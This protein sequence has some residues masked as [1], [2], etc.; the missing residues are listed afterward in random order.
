MKEIPSLIFFVRRVKW[1]I[2]E[3]TFAGL[4]YAYGVQKKK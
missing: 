3:G 2:T 4:F 1:L